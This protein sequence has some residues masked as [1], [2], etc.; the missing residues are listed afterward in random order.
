[1]TWDPAHLRLDSIKEHD[2]ITTTQHDVR[3]TVIGAGFDTPDRMFATF[4]LSGQPPAR[5]ALIPCNEIEPLEQD[6]T[7][8]MRICPYNKSPGQYDLVFWLAPPEY[9]SDQQDKRVNDVPVNDVAVLK[10]AITV[11][12]GSAQ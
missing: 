3:L 6:Y 9:V 1:M 5:Q 2:P 11:L 7:V 10:N 8:G 12:P 4:V